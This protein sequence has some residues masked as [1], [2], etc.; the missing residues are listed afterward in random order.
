MAKTINTICTSQICNQIIFA[1]TGGHS[2]YEDHKLLSLLTVA[3]QRQ[4][5][6]E[7]SPLRLMA[8]RH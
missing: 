1:K 8:D 2:D 5:C 3:G 7:L 6:T 4:I